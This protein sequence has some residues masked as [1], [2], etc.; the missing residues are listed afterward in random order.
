M[1]DA[2]D[3]RQMLLLVNTKRT[4]PQVLAGWMDPAESVLGDWPG[5]PLTRPQAIDNVGVIAGVCDEAFVAV[6]D[7][8]GWHVV[9]GDRVR[10]DGRPSERWSH[11]VGTAN[12]GRRFGQRGAARP[13]QSIPLSILKAGQPVHVEERDGK[14]VTWAVVAG[15][16]IEATEGTSG[17]VVTAPRGGSVTVHATA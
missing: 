1:E 7:V 6:F 8:N 13:T 5:L 10:F 12:P 2:E 11:L 3:S 15:Y 4:W 16:R 9:D 14:K 17:L